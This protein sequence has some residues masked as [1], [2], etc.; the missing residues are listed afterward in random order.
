MWSLPSCE[1]MGR[2]SSWLSSRCQLLEMFTFFIARKTRIGNDPWGCMIGDES[3]AEVFPAQSSSP[4]TAFFLLFF[5]TYT[6]SESYH[7]D[8]RLIVGVNS[9]VFH[10]PPLNS[11]PTNPVFFVR[12][13]RAISNSLQR[14]RRIKVLVFDLIII[15]IFFFSA[16]RTC[17]SS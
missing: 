17:L 3:N 8:V 15:V 12:A 9:E 11:S 7:A 6:R 2:T 16:S 5:H 13:S 10:S 1:W 14:K 4:P